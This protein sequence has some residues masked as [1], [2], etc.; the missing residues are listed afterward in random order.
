MAVLVLDDELLLL[1]SCRT[2]WSNETRSISSKIRATVRFF[3]QITDFFATD[4]A[5]RIFFLQFFL[6]PF[7][8]V[9]FEPTLHQTGTF[10][11][12]STD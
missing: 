7:A 5:A 1:I 12:R 11:G 4:G 10:E 8:A 6:P 2:F 3:L 9:R